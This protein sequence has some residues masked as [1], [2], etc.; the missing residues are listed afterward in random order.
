MGDHHK[1]RFWIC[2]DQHLLR[3]HATRS[4]T[5]VPSSTLDL[6]HYHL[7][8]EYL[9][10]RSYCNSI[11]PKNGNLRHGSGSWMFQ[12]RSSGFHLSPIRCLH[13]RRCCVHNM[14]DSPSVE[15]SDEYKSKDLYSITAWTRIVVSEYRAWF[16]M[17]DRT[18]QPKGDFCQHC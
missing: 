16:P 4:S 13:H 7:G 18:Y 11:R 2:K 12:R 15:P 3:P 10:G 14:P 9:G 8:Y 5:T 1:L 17:L 6:D